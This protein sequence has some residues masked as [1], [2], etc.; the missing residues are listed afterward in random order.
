MTGYY[1][2]SVSTNLQLGL[3]NFFPKN[4]GKIRCFDKNVFL[5]FFFAKNIR[6]MDFIFIIARMIRKNL[7]IISV[8]ANK[9]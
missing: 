8:K 4:F 3:Y 7:V 2:L 6:K 5:F 9:T 1:I